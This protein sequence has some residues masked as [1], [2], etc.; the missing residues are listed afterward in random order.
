MF[1]MKS[2]YKILVFVVLGAFAFPNMAKVLHNCEATHQ[3]CDH[4]HADEKR[5]N[6]L[7]SDVTDGTNHDCYI[8]NFHF[9]G[10]EVENQLL[11]NLHTNIYNKEYASRLLSGYHSIIFSSNPH[12]GPPVNLI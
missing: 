5:D 9:A 6:G 1:I 12:R 3:Y 11:L 8:C 7:Y 2:W 4:N 10:F